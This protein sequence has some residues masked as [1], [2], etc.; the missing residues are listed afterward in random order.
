MQNKSILMKMAGSTKV[1]LCS[2]EH[3]KLAKAEL[4]YFFSLSLQEIQPGMYVTDAAIQCQ[5]INNFGYTKLYGILVYAGK[6]FDT[7]QIA[8]HIQNSYKLSS[9]TELPEPLTTYADRLYEQLEQP[10]V[11]LNTPDNEYVLCYVDAMYYVI[12]IRARNTDQPNTRRAHLKEHAHPTSLH[13]KL[14]KAMIALLGQKKFHDPF[15]G[16]GGI[17]LEGKR[18]GYTVSG[19]DIRGDLIEKANKNIG[20]NLCYVQDATT[21]T[22]N[23]ALVTDLPYGKNSVLSQ[24]KEV[25]F[26]KFFS[27]CKAPKLVVGVDS[28]T[29]LEKCIH[30]YVVEDTFIVYVHKSLSRK[31]YVLTM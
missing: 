27:K 19:S 8:S 5:T 15:C 12:R 4:E 21:L 23:Q 7:K 28:E 17:V 22:W 30:P 26:K 2:K 6:V 10:I 16:T 24:E 25:L 20:E 31:I 18:L 13:P 3:P 14:A 29:P 1:F 11:D 9:G